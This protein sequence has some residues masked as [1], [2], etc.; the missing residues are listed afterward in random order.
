M[1]LHDTQVN[2]DLTHLIERLIELEEAFIAAMTLGV[3]VYSRPLGF[4]VL[5]STEHFGLFQNVEKVSVRLYNFMYLHQLPLSG[6]IYVC[7]PTLYVYIYI[8]IYICYVC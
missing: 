8:Y 5:T 4:H 2:S 7:N 1:A 6:S 3:Q